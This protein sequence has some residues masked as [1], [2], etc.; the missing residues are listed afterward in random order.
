MEHKLAVTRLA[1]LAHESRL[2]VFRLLV[3]QGPAGLTPGVMAEQLGIAPSSLSFHLKE[4]A[5]ADLVSIRQDGRR[6]IY[7]ANF[8]VMNTLMAFLTEN[9]CGG[10]P[11]S[12]VSSPACGGRCE[13]A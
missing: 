1:A 8:D 10:N 6:L 3:Q 9:C 7:A 5:H 4:L 2:A 11:C 12:P 13:T